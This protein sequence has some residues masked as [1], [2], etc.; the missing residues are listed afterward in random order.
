[1]MRTL[2]LAL[3]AASVVAGAA[4]SS[5]LSAPSNEFVPEPLP[6]PPALPPANPVL[7]IDDTH[8]HGPTA[9]NWLDL[10]VDSQWLT[11]STFG[12]VAAFDGQLSVGLPTFDDRQ[13]RD[14]LAPLV[15]YQLRVRTQSFRSDG[16]TQAG[17]LTI[18]VQRY[19]PVNPIAISP[20]VFAHVG[21][22]AALSTPWLA[23]RFAVPPAAVQVLHAVDTELAQNGWSPRPVSP[24]LRA[25]FLA[26]RSLYA[27]LGAAPE[28]FVPAVGPNE[29]DLRFHAALGLS[30]G[31]GARAAAHR[32][33]LSLEYRGRVRL[34][35]D[36]A[37]VA[38][39]DSAG[40]GLQVDLGP[41][42]IQ[43]LVTT[44]LAH[45]SLDVWMVGLRLQL[46][47]AKQGGS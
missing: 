7:T 8:T 5:A 17:P 1:V 16:D 6:P 31:C 19:I 3:V 32:P 41:L 39:R 33:M 9:R 11:S 22:E 27:E 21:I 35:A 40:L 42:I 47:L 18:A 4:P 25:D 38:Y 36:D 12:D 20:L 45:D 30:F 15:P 46:G 23:G 29:Y 44:V 2:A 14:I 34:H 43:P 10:R 13:L 37:P 26:C 28:L 24:Y